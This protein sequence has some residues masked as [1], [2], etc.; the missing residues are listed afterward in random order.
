MPSKGVGQ[1]P[2]RRCE[3]RYNRYYVRYYNRKYINGVDIREYDREDD[4]YHH[5]GSKDEGK[6]TDDD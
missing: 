6:R 2:V 1:V 5:F 3:D 4:R